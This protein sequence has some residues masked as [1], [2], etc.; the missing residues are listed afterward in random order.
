MKIP[1]EFLKDRKRGL[2][3]FVEEIINNNYRCQNCGDR[4]F[5]TAFYAD[6]RYSAR[7]GAPPTTPKG[8]VISFINNGWWIG[9]HRTAVCPVCKGDP[10]RNVQPVY[11]QRPEFFREQMGNLDGAMQNRHPAKA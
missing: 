7:E 10:S 9:E 2:P 11:V 4:G 5:I 3:I 8:R 6:H 1:Q